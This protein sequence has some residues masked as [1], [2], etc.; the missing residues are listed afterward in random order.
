MLCNTEIANG[1]AIR[2]LEVNDS[3]FELAFVG[4]LRQ[5]GLGE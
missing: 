1:G 3:I 5:D 2:R 4:G